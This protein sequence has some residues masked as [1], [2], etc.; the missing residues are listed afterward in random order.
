MGIRSELRRRWFH[1]NGE[2]DYLDKTGLIETNFIGIFIG[3]IGLVGWQVYQGHIHYTWIIIASF[4][5][6]K[7]KEEVEKKD[8][9][10]ILYTI[11]EVTGIYKPKSRIEKEEDSDDE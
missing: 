3:I 11:G 8:D 6:R 1:N 7:F 2:S 4:M 9:D 5:I 10:F